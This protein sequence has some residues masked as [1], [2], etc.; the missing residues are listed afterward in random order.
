MHPPS[1]QNF[2]SQISTTIEHGLEDAVDSDA[3]QPNVSQLALSEML[4]PTV[5]RYFETLNAGNF[6][7]T[8]QL[9]AIAGVMKPPF[10]P[11]I[12]GAEAILNYLQTEAPGMRLKPHQSNSQRQENG[13]TEVNVTG[14]VQTTFFTVNVTWQFWLSPLQEIDRVQINLIASPQ[15]LLR[16]RGS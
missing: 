5:L 13:C 6:Q 1:I 8:T 12:V 15:E 14:K 4:E 3:S 7:A 9:F 10:D 16:L 2:P 11:P